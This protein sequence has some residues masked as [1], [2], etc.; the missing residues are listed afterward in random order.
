MPF[1]IVLMPRM[2][3]FTYAEKTDMH[4]MY[5]RANG[6][7]KVVLRIHLVQFLDRQMPDH[8]PYCPRTWDGWQCWEDTP[9]GTTAKDTCQGHI[10]FDN[11]PPSCPIMIWFNEIHYRLDSHLYVMYPLSADLDPF[12]IF[13]A[14]GCRCRP[15]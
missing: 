13:L 7:D 12:Q 6:Y 11:D 8:G 4:Y 15:L 14:T 3:D 5:G 1:T 9:G 10:Y 2:G